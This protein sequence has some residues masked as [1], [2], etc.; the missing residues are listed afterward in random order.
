M[1]KLGLIGGGSHCSQEHLPALAACMERHPGR[2]ELAAFC[3]RDAGVVD[4]IAKTYPFSRYYTDLVQMLRAEHLDGCLAVTPVEQTATVAIR[5]LEAGVPLLM[6]KPPGASLEEARR[7]CRAVERTGTPAMVSM[8]RRFDP[9]LLKARDWLSGRPVTSVCVSV[10]R[11][12]RTE[13]AF[14]KDTAI[15]AVDAIRF[16]AGEVSSYSADITVSGNVP[17]YT[18]DLQFECGATGVL[19]V[20]PDCGKVEE[21][22]GISGP[23]FSLN[24]RSGFMDAGSLDITEEGRVVLA[25]RSP[26]GTPGFVRNGTFN[27][28]AAFIDALE[29]GR[30]PAPSPSAVFN[31]MRL[32]HDI[33]ALAGK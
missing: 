14:F 22:Y 8:N 1:L 16:L 28:T 21:R 4:R 33:Q 15:H 32:C 19:S 6:E 2:I 9:A 23:G 18:V 3:D 13:A 10:C 11:I 25:L 30:P 26:A 12:G 17:S 29:L 24:A 5:V 20:H 7:I 27:E 31:S